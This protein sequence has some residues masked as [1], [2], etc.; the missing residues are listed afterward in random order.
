MTSITQLVCGFK[1]TKEHLLEELKS[2]YDEIEVEDRNAS[3]L[4]DEIFE[5]FP[6]DQVVYFDTESDDNVLVGIIVINL[7]NKDCC[8]VPSL[9]DISKVDNL[10]REWLIK[11]KLSLDKYT[12]RLYVY[13]TKY[14]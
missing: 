6:K 2:K 10:F 5:I 13:T 1:F 8:E 4:S 14:M 11:N 9:S 3:E 7:K 12:P